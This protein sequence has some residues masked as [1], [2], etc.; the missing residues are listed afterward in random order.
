VPGFWIITHW[1]SLT[2]ALIGQSIWAIFLGA[3][4][5]LSTIIAMTLFPVA[6]RF[7]A[8]AIA[9]NVGLTIFGSTAPYASTWLVATTGSPLAPAFYLTAAAVAGLVAVV[10]GLREDPQDGP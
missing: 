3:T 9:F 6:I 10:I 4:Y 7:T 5:T 8:L 1:H 2:G